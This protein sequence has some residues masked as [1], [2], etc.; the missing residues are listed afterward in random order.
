MALP[1]TILGGWWLGRVLR[2]IDWRRAGSSGAV[3]L[4]GAAPAA[5]FLLTI[6][7]RS[8]PTLGRTLSALT[9]VTQWLLALVLLAGLGYLIWRW[10]R[11]VGGWMGARL[12]GLGLVALLFL[13][14]IRF[15]Y[16]LTYVNYD[17]ATEY[18]VYAHATPDVKRMLKQIEELSRRTTD[19]L[20]IVVAYDDET[21]YPYWWYLRNYPNQKYYG[22]NP[23]RELRDAPVILVGDNNFD[24]IEPVVGQAYHQFDYIRI[25]WPNQ[26][27]YNLT[28]ERMKAVLD[29]LLSKPGLSECI[30]SL[31]TLGLEAA[32]ILIIGGTVLALPFTI[33]SYFFSLRFFITVQEKRRKKHILT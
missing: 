19:G 10:I 27:Y 11:A 26:D 20:D 7:L 8:Q 14:T 31:G 21:T 12:L 17:L 2:R 4:I 13:L 23:T 29:V 5:L 3:W 24:K 33:A 16:M 6:L 30:Q 1:M 28:W 32:I 22:P 18:L 9:G 25:W 15:T